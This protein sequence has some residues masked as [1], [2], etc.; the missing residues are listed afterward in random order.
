ML[1]G[2]PAPGSLGDGSVGVT[3][4]V[5]EIVNT[6]FGEHSFWAVGEKPSKTVRPR[7]VL[8]LATL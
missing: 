6:D 8:D 5:W 2:P 4:F 7:D 1:V 3:G